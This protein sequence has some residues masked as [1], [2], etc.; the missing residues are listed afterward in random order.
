MV[1]GKKSK[2][3]SKTPFPPGSPETA[4]A[5]DIP[6]VIRTGYNYGYRYQ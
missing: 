3:G 4:E 2:K 5:V 1:A 6:K